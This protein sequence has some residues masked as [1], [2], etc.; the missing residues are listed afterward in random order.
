VQL[1][2]IIP[3]FRESKWIQAVQSIES[4]ENI[5]IEVIL[6]DGANDPSFFEKWQFKIPIT[7]I[8]ELDNGVYD[9]MNKGIEKATGTWILI[10]GANDRL[11]D[12]NSLSNLPL[13]STC[14]LIIGSISN[15]ESIHKRTPTHHYSALNWK[16]NWKHT[17]HQQ[18][19][20]YR[21]ETCFGNRTFNSNY[22]ILGDYEFH[23][24]LR[25][26]G[27]NTYETK[28]II[29]ICDGNGLSKQYSKALYK[30]ELKLKKEQLPFFIWLIQIPWVILKFAYKKMG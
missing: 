8:H 19:I 11:A 26:N 24:W 9:A 5:S 3:C 13:N 21:K 16:I 2:V 30:E 23:L 12:N 17:L 25:K 6:I 14:D 22:K 15:E 10:L 27:I 20:L 4:Q 1:S 28:Q 18:G 29:A 7:F